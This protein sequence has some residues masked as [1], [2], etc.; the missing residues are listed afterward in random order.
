MKRKMNP[1][2]VKCQRRQGTECWWASVYD[3]GP[4]ALF[5]PKLARVRKPAPRTGSRHNE[6][7]R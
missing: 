3:A 1:E 2:C 7:R 5:L 6:S 4:C